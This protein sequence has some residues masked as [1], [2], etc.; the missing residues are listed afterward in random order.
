[1]LLSNA[2]KTQRWCTAAALS[3]VFLHPLFAGCGLI[4]GMAASATG[5]HMRVIA[6]FLIDGGS[7]VLAWLFGG[8]AW[9]VG[10][11]DGTKRGHY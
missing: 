3:R 5:V 11:V 4:P 2:R 7:E 9:T 8:D 10:I 6:L 1:M